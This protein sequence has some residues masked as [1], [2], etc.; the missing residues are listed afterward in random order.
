LFFSLSFFGYV[1][2]TKL[3]SCQLWAHVKIATSRRIVSSRGRTQLRRHLGLR[4]IS[5]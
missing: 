5:L 4:L 3:V 2:Q 1:R